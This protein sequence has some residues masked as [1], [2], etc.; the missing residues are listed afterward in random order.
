MRLDVYKIKW[1]RGRTTK[2]NRHVDVL[3]N[4]C[5]HQVFSNV[6]G[7][8]HTSLHVLNHI[9]IYFHPLQIKHHKEVRIQK[10]RNN[11]RRRMISLASFFQNP[12]SYLSIS[13]LLQ[14][15]PCFS[16]LIHLGD[17]CGI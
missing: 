1:S 13:S 14:T 17:V 7:C 11:P 16:N 2:L 6:L 3:Q 5:M 15:T 12:F 4:Y 8:V 9:S 10:T